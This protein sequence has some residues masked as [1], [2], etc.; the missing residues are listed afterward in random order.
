MWVAC[1]PPCS[2]KCYLL[3]THETFRNPSPHY[4]EINDTTV[5][6]QSHRIC[7]GPLFPY[8]SINQFI[9]AEKGLRAVKISPSPHFFAARI[10][11]PLF[12]GLAFPFAW[13]LAAT[14]YDTLPHYHTWPP[15][16][17]THLSPFFAALSAAAAKLIFT[18]S[19]PACPGGRKEVFVLCWCVLYLIID[20][21]MIII[22]KLA[23]FC[24]ESHKDQDLCLL[25]PL[26]T[27]LAFLLPPV[28]QGPACPKVS[29]GL[30][31]M[32]LAGCPWSW[33]EPT[34]CVDLTALTMR[35]TTTLQKKKKCEIVKILHICAFDKASLVIVC[36]CLRR[37]TFPAE[38]EFSYQR[39]ILI[40]VA[41][42]WHGVGCKVAV[43]SS[44]GPRARRQLQVMRAPLLPTSQRTCTLRPPLRSRP[45][46]SDIHT[47]KNT[48]VIDIS[49]YII[50]H[51]KQSLKCCLELF[52]FLQDYFNFQ[53]SMGDWQEMGLKVF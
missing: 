46:L 52:K 1:T 30:Q 11:P 14:L 19:S 45:F 26:P 17:I 21:S 24:L 7:P 53:K 39:F 3:V 35:H 37:E 10:F 22:L 40:S 36:T 31:A 50:Q 13:N 49:Q 9:C 41:S 48:N 51:W 28:F 42:L 47:H 44:V 16:F 38:E 18:P 5:R 8:I 32:T 23:A 29:Q 34:T 25:C 33:L 12:F 6:K 43:G 2:L 20:A 15:H 4:M 27:F